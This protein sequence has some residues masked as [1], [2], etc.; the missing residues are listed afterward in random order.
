M[1][2]T[3]EGIGYQNTDTS[4]E[5]TSPIKDKLILREKIYN[6]MVDTIVERKIHIGLSG[7][8]LANVLNLEVTTVRP[9][10]TELKDL[11]RI[12]PQSNRYKNSNGKTEIMYGFDEEN[13]NE[14]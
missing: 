9:R 4:Y 13:P 2:Y 3:K 14:E 12:F 11:K 7:T 8:Q 1:P 10:L 5:A 6:Y